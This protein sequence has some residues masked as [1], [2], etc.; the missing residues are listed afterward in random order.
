MEGLTLH[1]LRHTLASMVFALGE[2]AGCVADQR[3]IP[4][5][6][7]PAAGTGRQWAPRRLKERVKALADGELVV[8]P[9][10]PGRGPLARVAGTEEG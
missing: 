2:D 8:S 5:P 9:D 7:S 1:G 3:A 10:P 6:D 4:T